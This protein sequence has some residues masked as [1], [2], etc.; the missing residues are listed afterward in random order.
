MGK[1]DHACGGQ[2]IL[3]KKNFWECGDEQP[4]DGTNT[5]LKC[6][7]TAACDDGKCEASTYKFGSDTSCPTN[8]AYVTDEDSCT[9]ALEFFKTE[10]QAGRLKV[11]EG[12]ATERTVPAD[13][14]SLGGFQDH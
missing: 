10:A 14:L 8:Y 12:K 11:D 7:T 2:C 3:T 1:P 5:Y 6:G 9:D 13:K 4:E